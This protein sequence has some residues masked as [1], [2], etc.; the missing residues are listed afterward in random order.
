M[1][2]LKIKIITR[3]SSHLRVEQ[4]TSKQQKADLK[5]KFEQECWLCYPNLLLILFTQ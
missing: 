4:H 3:A 5:K 1:T 2:N